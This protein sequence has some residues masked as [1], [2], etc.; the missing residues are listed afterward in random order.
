MSVFIARDNEESVLLFPLGVKYL[1]LPFGC[2]KI[3]RGWV[4]LLV[5][6]PHPLPLAGPP[7]E[8]LHL[9]LNQRVE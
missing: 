6:I 4:D 3:T 5:L 8:P 2:C 1:L 7:V 9:A